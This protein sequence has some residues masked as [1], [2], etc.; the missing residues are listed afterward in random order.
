MP[1]QTLSLIG[2][3]IT[4]ALAASPATA[5]T[6]AESI[7]IAYRTNPNILAQRAAMRALDENYVQARAT[8]APRIE[9]TITEGY[10]WRKP[11]YATHGAEGTSQTNQLT[12]SQT[13]YSHGRLA[14]RLGGVEAEI[15]ASRESLRQQEMELLLRVTEPDAWIQRTPSDHQTMP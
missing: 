9:A 5:D 7:A 6:L 13:I 3:V 14:S 10:G 8:Y 1:R 12:L 4:S 2:L 11:H 15:R